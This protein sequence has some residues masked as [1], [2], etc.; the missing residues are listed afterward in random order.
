MNVLEGM[1]V[2]EIRKYLIFR[3][4]KES[5]SLIDNQELVNTQK[6]YAKSI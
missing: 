6:Q 5:S 3:E 1:S 4:E 2:E